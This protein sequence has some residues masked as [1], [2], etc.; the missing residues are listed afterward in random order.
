MQAAAFA[1]LD[2]A[3]ANGVRYFDVAHGYGLSEDFLAAWLAS[4]DVDPSKVAVGTKWGYDYTAKW[5][6]EVPS[7]GAH[8]VKDHSLNTL[9]GHMHTSWTTLGKQGYLHLLQIH[10][11]GLGPNSVLDDDNVLD[12]LVRIRGD[13]GL[14]LGLSATGPHQAATI[15]KAIAL[16]IFDSVQAT[17]NVLD[18]SAGPAL[19][20]AKDSG[21]DVIV[22]EALANGRALKH[23]ALLAL[24]KEKGLAPDVVALAACLQQPWQPTVLSGAVTP[25]QMVSNAQALKVADSLSATDLAALFKACLVA[26]EEYWAERAALA[27]N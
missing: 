27:W 16:G 26:P 24:A 23:P 17:F 18:Q 15:D 1:V 9:L 19:G 2:A 6:V 25:D 3:W 4:R 11:A 8:E 5:Q 7:G 22:K 13:F 21:M 10:S 12:R 20:R 14:R